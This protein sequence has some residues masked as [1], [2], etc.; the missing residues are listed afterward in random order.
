VQVWALQQGED[1]WVAGKSN[2]SKLTFDQELEAAI[3][4]VPEVAPEVAA[5]ESVTTSRQ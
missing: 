1:V 5:A 4:Q 3:D 2:R